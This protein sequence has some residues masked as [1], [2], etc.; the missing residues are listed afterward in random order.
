LTIGIAF[1]GDVDAED[2]QPAGQPLH[3]LDQLLVAG[4]GADQ[5]RRPVGEGMGA[6][7]HDTEP[8]PCCRVVDLG[9]GLEQVALGLRDRSADAGDDLDARLEQLVFGL[10]MLTPVRRAQL[11]E[12]LARGATG[13]QLPRLEVDELEL[14]LDTDARAR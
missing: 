12:D 1:S 2:L 7:A 4:V 5:L 9:Q 6:R 10:G 11:G 8:S 14:P 3:V 13:R